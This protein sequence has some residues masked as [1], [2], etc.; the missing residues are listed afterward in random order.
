MQV[1]IKDTEILQHYN[2]SFT[3]DFK[4]YTNLNVENEK[5]LVFLNAAEN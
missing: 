1:I 5:R 4:H 2:S 3:E